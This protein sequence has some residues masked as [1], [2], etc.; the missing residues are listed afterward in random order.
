[1]SENQDEI[2]GIWGRVRA[3]RRRSEVLNQAMIDR[4]RTSLESIESFQ[5]H[6][7]DIQVI[8]REI[9]PVNLPWSKHYIASL[10]I[11]DGNW[12]S[13]VFHLTFRDMDELNMKLIKDLH[14]YYNLKK[15]Y[16]KEAIQ[17]V[18]G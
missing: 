12:V 1:M 11:K 3:S 4:S 17:K 9:H 16:G 18:F 15:V 14:M 6:L 13:H 8:V 5:Y 10:Q 7:L 2:G